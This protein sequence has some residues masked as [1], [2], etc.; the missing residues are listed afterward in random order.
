MSDQW[1]YCRDVMT[2]ALNRCDVID[3]DSPGNNFYWTYKIT[4]DSGTRIRPGFSNV[5]PG[6]RYYDKEITKEIGMVNS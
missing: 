6:D 4:H 3:M 2:E 5:L 1:C